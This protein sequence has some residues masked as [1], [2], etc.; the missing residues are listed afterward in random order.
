MHRHGK[1][2]AAKLATQLPHLIQCRPQGL[3]LKLAVLA[4]G[5]SSSPAASLK[6]AK[7]LVQREPRLLTHSSEVRKDGCDAASVL[8]DVAH[9]C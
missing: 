6:V 4:D 2:G 9:P 5:L 1:E 3:D 7:Q 8:C